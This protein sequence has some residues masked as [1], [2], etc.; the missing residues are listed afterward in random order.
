MS[1]ITYPKEK[2]G[3]VY[4]LHLIFI[5]MIVYSV[6]QIYLLITDY[7]GEAVGGSVHYL[8][9]VA[10][11]EEFRPWVYRVLVPWTAQLLERSTGMEAHH[12]LHPIMV[13][14]GVGLY[15]A[16]KHLLR[17]TGRKELQSTT[18]AFIFTE[19]FVLSLFIHAKVYDIPTA[20]LF[21]MAFIFLYKREYLNYTLLFPLLCLNRE[22]G[23][24][25]ILVTVFWV[26]YW[27]FLMKPPGNHW[28]LRMIAVVLWEIVMYLGIRAYLLYRFAGF[29]GDTYQW[30]LLHNLQ[31]YLDAPVAALLLFGVTGAMLYFIWK[32]F[33][34]VD[35]HFFIAA[36]WI[37]FP[38]QILLYLTLGLI[39]ELRVFAESVPLIAVLLPYGMEKVLK[40]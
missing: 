3:S 30:H 21:T 23:F 39:W 32:A 16:L 15:F 31:S 25:L 5:P 20:L 6:L 4:L 22:T 9:L 27:R 38:V 13:I 10:N 35:L 40:R 7:F 37:V 34:N 18:L 19:L 8:Q 28:N 11:S 24:L 14:S 17:L 36:F 29:P 2:S 33:S 12:W 26:L 1:S